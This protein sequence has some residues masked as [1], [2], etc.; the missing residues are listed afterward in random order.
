MFA[1]KK[2]TTLQLKPSNGFLQILLAIQLSTGVEWR[3]DGLREGTA[4][5]AGSLTSCVLKATMFDFL[6]ST[7]LR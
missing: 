3:V 7:G 4:F 6:G 5:D 1:S 2:D